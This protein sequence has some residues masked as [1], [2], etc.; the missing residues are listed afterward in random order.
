MPLNASS[1]DLVRPFP[2][3]AGVVFATVADGSGGWYVGGSFT[4]VGGLPRSHLA[5]ILADGSVAAWNPIPSGGY[6]FTAVYSLAVGAG[7]VYV[8]GVFASVD[9]QPRNNIA[10]VNA[11]TG[12]VSNWSGGVN[13]R[14]AALA[15]SGGTVY[16]G[17]NFTNIDGQV[18][19]TYIAAFDGTTGQVTPWNPSASGPVLALAASGNLVYA[20]GAFASIG[21][22]VRHHIA[23]L[24]ATTGAAKS[25]DPN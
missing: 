19:R 7:T 4:A 3:V 15:V 14:V 22:Q 6:P 18:L 8:G 13:D 9:G 5:H 24:D 21:G 25:W 12:S 11:T 20:G 2:K 23:A 10:A 16:A 1:G 17:G